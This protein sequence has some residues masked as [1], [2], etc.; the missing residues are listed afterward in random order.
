MASLSPDEINARLKSLPGWQYKDNAISKMFRF[1][2]FMD[3]IRFI[4]R[5]AEIAET[6]DHHPDINI[7]YTR[8]TFNC[9]TH[10]EGGVTE[11]DFVLATNIEKAFAE[12]A[13]S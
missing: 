10:S 2:E 13:H 9:S 8:I 3:G 7:N 1:K 5:V 11:K 4:N 12:H 6:A